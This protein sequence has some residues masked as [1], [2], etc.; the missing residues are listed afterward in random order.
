MTFKYYLRPRGRPDVALVLSQTRRQKQRA[1]RRER[2]LT[3]DELLYLWSIRAFVTV[4]NYR[5]GYSGEVTHV[6]SSPTTFC[7][8]THTHKHTNTIIRTFPYELLLFTPWQSNLW[9]HYLLFLLIGAPGF[10]D[11]LYKLALLK[12]LVEENTRTLNTTNA[13][14]TLNTAAVSALTLHYKP[15]LIAK[16]LTEITLRQVA[17]KLLQLTNAFCNQI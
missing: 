4:M 2:V 5:V 8:K 6:A 15:S 12:Q 9:S 14:I 11:S 13:S 3:R 10:Y 16:V 7:P 17:S 1:E